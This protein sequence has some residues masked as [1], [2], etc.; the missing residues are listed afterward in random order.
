MIL[1]ADRLEAQLAGGLSPIY[2]ITGDDPLLT[3]EALDA[4]R[5]RARADGYT[6]RT[7]FHV[8]RYFD[9]HELTAASSAM[10]LFA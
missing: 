8:D 3:G 6:D 7:V 2:L 10:S 1:A 4:V 5:A 9:W